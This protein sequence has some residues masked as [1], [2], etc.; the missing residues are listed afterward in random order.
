MRVCIIWKNDYPWDVRIEKIAGSLRDAGHDVHLICSN[1]ECRPRHERT[2]NIS[3]WRLPQVRLG[4]LHAVINTPFFFNPV[5]LSMIFRVVRQTRANIIIVRDVPLVALAMVVGKF[6]N[7]PVLLD[8][9][10]NYPAM[11]RE[12]AK[13]GGWRARLTWFLKNPLVISWIE[14][15][16]VKH[17]EGILVVVEESLERL[18]RIG[19]R[20]DR[21]WVVSNTPI[22][23]RFRIEPQSEKKASI[24]LLYVGYVQAGRGLDV[25]VRGLC[26]IR[27]ADFDV[28]LTIVGDGPYTV[29]LKR[30]VKSCG[31]EDYVNWQG[32]IDNA[33]VP[34]RIQQCDVAII[35]HE[36]TEHTDTTIPNKLFDYMAC[37]KPVVVSDALPLKRI[38]TTE[39]CGVVFESGS[40]D[41]FAA[42]VKDQI[43]NRA[44]WSE[45][46][47]R[48]ISAI[49]TRYNWKIDSESMLDAIK[50]ICASMEV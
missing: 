41:S 32:W 10:E 6:L 44:H 22:I 42:A 3:I 27:D 19:A 15:Y 37:G 8:M 45:M 34:E 26:K 31:M 39:R 24:N 48:A 46:G 35:P 49:R 40:E 47:G 33:F 12:K 25:A 9:A 21:I 38:V 30:I 13:K 43:D 23:Q 5:W 29:E 16:A 11:Y 7:V 14:R 28:T 4:W 36:R 50:N 17:C 20:R 2:H 18:V 1:K